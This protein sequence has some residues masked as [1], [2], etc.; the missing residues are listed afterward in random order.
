V[1]NCKEKVSGGVL[2]GEGNLGQKWYIRLASCEG[3]ERS[4]EAGR[5]GMNRYG[6]GVKG[7]VQSMGSVTRF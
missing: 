2:D 5:G 6:G 1:Q 7:V 4:T 3:R